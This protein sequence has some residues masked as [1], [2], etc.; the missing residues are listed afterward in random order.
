MIKV[1]NANPSSRIIM[2]SFIFFLHFKRFQAGMSSFTLIICPLAQKIRQHPLVTPIFFCNTSHHILFAD[3]ILLFID[4]APTSIPQVWDT[5]EDFS[6]LWGYEINWSTNQAY[7]TP[8]EYLGVDIFP[9]HSQKLS[10]HFKK[11]WSNFQ[12]P[13]KCVAIVK[14]DIL[15]KSK[16]LVW[17]VTPATP[18]RV[19]GIR[20]KVLSPISFGKANSLT[21][22]C[23]LCIVVDWKVDLLSLISR[24]SFGNICFTLHQYDCMHQFLRL[25]C[26]MTCSLFFVYLQLRSS[27]HTYGVPWGHSLC[28]HELHVIFDMGVQTSSFRL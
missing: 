14:M 17:Y 2:A 6:A 23:H 16:P 26:F 9:S 13:C 5:Y 15:P 25:D 27:M 11:S 19:I 12:F 28:S 24:C 3:D 21:V 22:S 8:S 20:C 4:K 10:G 1:L 7:I 18:S